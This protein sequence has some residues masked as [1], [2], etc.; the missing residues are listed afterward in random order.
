ML[1]SASRG[2]S[3]WSGGLSGPGGL[4]P[5]GVPGPGGLP[6][7]GG[8]CSWEGGGF[9]LNACWDTNPTCEQNDRQV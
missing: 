5:G 8:V 1:E 2:G 7:P 6:G 3:A 4:L 9:C